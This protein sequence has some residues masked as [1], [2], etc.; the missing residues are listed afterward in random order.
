MELPDRE[1]FLR[2][3]YYYQGVSRI[4]EEMDMNVSTVKTHLARGRQ[5][6]KSILQ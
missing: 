3:Y 2:H 5:K 6:L 4:A 1:I